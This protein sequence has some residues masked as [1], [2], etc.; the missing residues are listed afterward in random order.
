[1][2]KQNNSHPVDP[3]EI[4]KHQLIWHILAPVLVTCAICLAVCLFL[5]LESSAQSQGTE[6]WANISIMFL[7]L[8]AAFLGFIGLIVVILFSI[9]FGKW[10][11]TLPPS[12]QLIRNR[13]I[14]LNNS[15]QS[16]AQKPAKP[17][18]L[19]KAIISGVKAIFNK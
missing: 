1:M 13:L 5:L 7:I 19:M 4:H 12:L 3:F 14:G 6:Q 10:N 18:I 17:I 11:K 16:I 2:N 8:P 9:L 15:I